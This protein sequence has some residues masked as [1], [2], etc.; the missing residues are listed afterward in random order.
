M[1]RM[2]IVF[3]ACWLLLT[4]AGAEEASLRI[5]PEAT[6]H[7]GR[8]MIRWEDAAGA[9]PYTLTYMYAEDTLDPQAVFFEQDIQTTACALDYM[10]PGCPYEICVTDSLGQSDRIVLTVPDPGAFEDG[11]LHAGLLHAQTNLRS[12]PAGAKESIRAEK[13]LAAADIL[14]RMDTRQFGFQ[15]CLRFPALIRP[16]CY[17]TTLALHA[18]DGFAFVYSLG[19][20]EYNS[21]DSDPFTLCW[22]FIGAEFF[23]ELQRVTGTIPPGVYTVDSYWNGMYAAGT[24]FTLR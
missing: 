7:D 22:P 23:E 14:Q 17:H 5:L 16:R 12:R 18:P 9:A 2:L 4:G 20:V 19:S 24:A 6:L 21:Y 10:I 8:V 3:A 15:F 13:T 1:K 11:K